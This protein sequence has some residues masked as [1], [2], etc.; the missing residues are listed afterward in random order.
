MSKVLLRAGATT[1]LGSPARRAGLCAGGDYPSTCRIRTH[2]RPG[3]LNRDADAPN[4]KRTTQSQSRTATALD[5]Q[6][7]VAGTEQR[8]E[9]NPVKSSRALALPLRASQLNCL[10]FANARYCLYENGSALSTLRVHCQE[11]TSFI[12]HVPHIVPETTNSG[13]PYLRFA[14]KSRQIHHLAVKNRARF[15][16]A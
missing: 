10:V 1:L 8:E 12:K 11:S 14:W 2:A 15:C 3:K 6:R 5:R 4:N 9:P 16:H 13:R 7:P